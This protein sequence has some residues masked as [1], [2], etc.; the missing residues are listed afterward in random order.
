MV[1]V[2]INVVTY[3]CRSFCTVSKFN[4]TL[5]FCIDFNK[6]LNIKVNYNPSSGNRT[7]GQT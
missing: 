3:V 5:Y 6:F 7:K 4:Q 1:T 2:V